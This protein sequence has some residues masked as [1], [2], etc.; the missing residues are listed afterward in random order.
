MKVFIS[1]SGERSKFV[2]QALR[3]WI[4]KVMQVVKPWMS[5]ED[6]SGGTRWSAEIAGELES[7]NFGII[8]LTAENQHNPWIMFES[9]ALS[10]TISQTFVCP[11]LIDLSPSQLSGPMAQFQALTADREGTLRLLN[12][13]NEALLSTE[14]TQINEIEEIFDVWWAKLEASLKDLPAAE[15]QIEKRSSEDILEEIV[16]NTREQL[17][18][19]EI[20]LNLIQG[21]DPKLNQLLERLEDFFKMGEVLFPPSLHSMIG[22]PLS[23][24]SDL[25]NKE[26][27]ITPRQIRKAVENIEKI[28]DMNSLFPDLISQL[29]LV[30]EES[31]TATEE[32][33][34]EEKPAQSPTKKRKS[35]R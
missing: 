28:Q 10:K 3:N 1:W 14:N 4:P 27:V 17:R 11:Y 6:I 12:T 21:R 32:L 30:Q 13:L 24:Q 9:G 16:K 5:K 25:I 2:A 26:K 7:S 19:E 22:E 35:R 33:L 18:R 8:C 15:R 23:E 29:K 31:Q 20:R 34:H